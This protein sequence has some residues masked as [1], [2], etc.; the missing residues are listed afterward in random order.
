MSKW[1]PAIQNGYK[2]DCYVKLSLQIEA[3]VLTTLIYKNSNN[4]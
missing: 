3:G 2:V 1:K 4:K